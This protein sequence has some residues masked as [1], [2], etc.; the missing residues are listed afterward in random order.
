[1]AV[2]LH[3]GGLTLL[4][5]LEADLPGNRLDDGEVGKAGR[6]VFGSMDTPT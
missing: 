1:M 3:T 4:V 6:F 2:E 5:E